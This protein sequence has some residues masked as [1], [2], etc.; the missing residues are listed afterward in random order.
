MAHS[1]VQGS[2]RKFTIFPKLVIALVIVVAPLYGIAMLMNQLGQSRMEQ[3]LSKSLEAKVD[4]YLNSLEVEHEHMVNLLQEYT[5]DKDIHH[6]TYLHETMTIS[7]FTDTI[8]RVQQKIEQLKSSSIYAKNVSVHLLTLGRSMN[9]EFSIA[10]TL[11]DEYKAIQPLIE[12]NGSGLFFREGRMFLAISYPAVHSITIHPGFI[13]SIELD[14]DAIKYALTSFHDYNKSGAILFYTNNDMVLASNSHHTI[15]SALTS[16]FAHK[17][18]QGD[19][20]GLEHIRQEADD[21]VIA[22]KYSELYGYYLVAYIPTHQI[23]GPIDTYKKLLWILSFMAFVIIIAYS[24]WIYRMIHR[25]MQKLIKAFR[26]VEQ[27]QLSGIDLPSS[28]DEFLYLFQRFNIMVGNLNELIN[29][30][31]EQ[32]LRAQSSELKQ[33]QAQINPHFLYNTYF[34]L[35]RL[36]KM[37]DNESVARFSQYLGEYFQYVTRTS[38][39]EITLEMEF[40]HSRTYAEIQ[41]IRFKNR[42]QVH[43]DELP[44]AFKSYRVPRLILQPI[45]ENAYKYGLEGRRKQGYIRVAAYVHDDVLNVSVEDN[46]EKLTDEDIEEL[47]HKLKHQGDEMEYTGILNVQRR[48]Q[49]RFGQNY[50]VYVARGEW[51]GLRVVLKMPWQQKLQ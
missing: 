35:Y 32:K 26:K 13:L 5:I 45:V 43:F 9:S 38:S 51:G 1:N 12:N 7:E 46:G 29:Q 11:T 17:Y 30:V 37:N 4:F 20:A 28:N 42:I 41:N 24:Y 40:K 3:E 14:L 31:Y 6:L 39:G 21:Y 22:Y 36:A 19:Y 49:I 33:L 47:K 50:G 8:S 2:R 16:L 18:D 48:L 15:H 44:E 23:L 27:R 34:I 10:D 25:P